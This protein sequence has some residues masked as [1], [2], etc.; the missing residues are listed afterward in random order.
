MSMKIKNGQIE[1]LRF[2]F[3][4]FVLFFHVEKYILG[5]SSTSNGVHLGFATHGSIG[6]EFFFLLSGYFMARSVFKKNQ[7]NQPY[8]LGKDTFSFMKNKYMSIFIYHI[9][10]FV[11]IFIEQ[12]VINKVSLVRSGIYLLKSIPGI[13]LIQ[14]VG[15]GGYIPNH[16]EWYISAMFVTLLILYPLCRKYYSMFVNVFAPIISLYTIGRLIASKKCLTGVLV[17]EGVFYRGLYRAVGEIALGAIL[18]EVTRNLMK[19]EYTSSQKR[20]MKI[21]EIVCYGMVFAFIF[22]TASKSF[23]LQALIL[24]CIGLVMSFVSFSEK[25]ILNNKFIYYLGKLSLGIYLCQMIAINFALALN[26]SVY[27]RVLIAI[28]LTISLAIICIALGDKI[29]KKVTN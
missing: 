12:M 13:L 4:V 22:T 2:I 27:S 5:E 16:V 25:S 6:V 20:N 8:D 17:L 15:I 1:L 3:S 19:K 26:V 23:E 24:L 21:C 28:I 14:I 11:I 10:A 29:E 9:I 7:S 18:F